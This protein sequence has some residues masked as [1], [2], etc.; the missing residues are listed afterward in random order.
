VGSA[1]WEEVNLLLAGRNHQYPFIEGREETGRPRSGESIGTEAGPIF[2]YRHTAYDRAV[3][4]GIVYRGTRHP[5]LRGK[6][7]FADNYSGKVFSIPA[8]GE[9]VDS[10]ELLAQ[11]DQVAQRGITSLIPSPEGEVLITTLGKASESTGRLLRLVPR[12]EAEVAAIATRELLSPAAAAELFRANCGRCH[13]VEGGGHGPEA[14]D[15]DVALPDFRDS[16][17]H[18]KR[19]DRR[20]RSVIAE[21]GAAHGLSPMMPPWR[22]ILSGPEVD[23]LVDHIRRLATTRGKA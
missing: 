13:G 11:A 10:V 3:V 16:A 8:T 6:Y 5:G 18:E 20:L 4:G 7:L 9:P 1:E 22:Q 15:M 17:F 12:D 19:D 14:R 21:G 2:T 23:A